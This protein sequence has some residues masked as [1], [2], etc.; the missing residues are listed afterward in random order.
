MQIVEERFCLL[1]DLAAFEHSRG[2]DDL[3]AHFF[4]S[5]IGDGQLCG[6]SVG[7]IDDAAVYGTLRDLSRDLFDV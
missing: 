5:G 3:T 1:G 2:I 4:G 7:L 6:V